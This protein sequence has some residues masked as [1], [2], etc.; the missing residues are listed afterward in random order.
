LAGFFYYIIIPLIIGNVITKGSLT[1]NKTI[2]MTIIDKKFLDFI[3][4]NYEQLSIASA[5]IPPQQNSSN[6]PENKDPQQ[7]KDKKPITIVF[8]LAHKKYKNSNGEVVYFSG[9]IYPQIHHK[10]SDEAAKSIY[11]NGKAIINGNEVT[12][13][14]EHIISEQIT[15]KLATL[16]SA[17]GMVDVN[18]IEDAVNGT[19]DNY[20]NYRPAGANKVFKENPDSRKYFVSLHCNSV[21][22]RNYTPEKLNTIKG[23]MAFINPTA[24]A[25]TKELS[26]QLA[27]YLLASCCEGEF[28]VSVKNHQVTSYKTKNS[29]N[30]SWSIKTPLN[31]DA[32][33]V[34]FELGYLTNPEDREKLTTEKG[35]WDFA[36]K[37]YDGLRNHFKERDGIEMPQLKNP[38]DVIAALASNNINID[39]IKPKSYTLD[40]YNSNNYDFNSKFLKLQIGQSPK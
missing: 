2:L 27:N 19:P 24:N 30:E 17:S 16:L 22:E 8:D 10:I 36:Y 23:P 29:K 18:I 7:E 11:E 9:A 26:T 15:R 20:M 21:D 28:C 25:E 33:S 4:N 34:L 38:E 31:P 1:E 40:R 35:Q 5:K 37:L 12:F 14:V 13:A 39:T 6:Q 3:S 32:A